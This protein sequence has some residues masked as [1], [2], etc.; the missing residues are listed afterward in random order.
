[1]L[2]ELFGSAL[3]YLI[4]G[5]ALLLVGIAAIT[6]FVLQAVLDEARLEQRIGAAV[7]DWTG[8]PLVATGGVD[9]EL[10]PQPVLTLHRPRLGAIEDGFVLSADRLDLDVAF[11]SLF[12]GSLAVDVASLIRPELRLGDNPRAAFDGL[13]ERLGADGERLPFRRLD[14]V[15]GTLATLADE[16]VLREIDG[17]LEREGETGGSRFHAVGRLAAGDGGSHLRLEG[18]L[19]SAAADRPLPLQLQLEAT[20][21]AVAH[22]LDF[23]GQLSRDAS[24]S[25][26][27]GRMTLDLPSSIAPLAAELAAAWP[28]LARLPL[29]EAPLTLSGDLSMTVGEAP[30]TLR[31]EQAALV[32]DGQAL[33][34]SLLLEGGVAP[35]IDL[36]LDADRLVLEDEVLDPARLASRLGEILPPD[37][38]G[39]IAL[40]AAV[41]EWRGEA[42]RQV[43][44]DLLLDGLGM[45][46]V[47]RATAVLPG[48]GDLA[49]TGQYGP[50]AGEPPPRL[51]GRLEAA[52]QAP[53][54]LAAAL[55]EPPAVLRHS[56][57]LAIEAD[58]EWQPT[59]L[60]LQNA[61]LRL[62]ALRAVG[63]LAYRG[64][65]AGRLPQVAVWAS[66][67]RLAL[68]DVVNPAS[69]AA[70]LDRLFEL[71]R[72][73]DLAIDLRVSRTSLAEARFGSLTARLD[74]SDGAVAIERL[75]LNDV[76]GSAVTLSGRVHAPSRTFELDLALDLASVSRLLRLGGA[77][78]PVALALLGPLNLRGELAGDL[79]R[80]ELT[81]V[82]DAD[83]F[84][85]R[86]VASITDWREHPSAAL[87]FSLDAGDA[88]PLIRQLGGVA[89][90]ETLA[91]GPLTAQVELDIVQGGLRATVL[92][93]SLG[94]LELV[95]EASRAD[96]GK[97]PPDRFDLRLGPLSGEMA[98]LLYRLATPPLDLVPGPPARWLGYWPAQELTWDWL[99]A[100][101]AE[102]AVTLLG[103]DPDTPPIE[104]R[105]QLRDGALTVPAFRWAGPDGL[106]DAGLALV[107][108]G[109]GGGV[110]LTLDLALER[111]SAGGVLA[112]VWPGPAAVHGTLD[113]EARLATRGGSLRA[114]VSNLQ[115]ALDLVLTDGVLGAASPADG[116][117]PVERLAGTL[118]VERGVI[119]PSASGFAFS[120]PDGA[121]L[122]EGYADLL[123]WIVDLELALDGHDGTPL[124]RQRLFG[125]LAE[126]VAL[127]SLRGALEGALPAP[128]E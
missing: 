67:D 29:P 91:Q 70:E 90:G 86:G 121:G 50:L 72:S 59:R 96:A 125:P 68:D 31:L 57:T 54:E 22:R 18:Q 107:A 30:P 108:R 89:V 95:L 35:E 79:D 14:F 37:L 27:A 118:A 103:G 17:E 13:A 19:G 104:I 10:L 69:P 32:L 115:G 101:E 11:W 40:R 48:P 80:A 24:A 61:D 122:I 60:T 127:P 25:G 1:M 75:S 100:H 84:T 116:G 82:L 38:S 66:I 65:A 64:D 58:L 8:H 15:G 42:F 123:A 2:P 81:A 88:A 106:I 45:V 16:V 105:S 53:A 36:R 98:A 28:G 41:V 126:P 124:V 92:E 3:R 111:F 102:L 63:G 43:N 76:A 56:T 119:S 74:S 112:P 23:R 109:P 114:L 34:G 128:E 71:A 9:L 78:P 7:L 62:D 4:G 110:D 12:S 39:P 52:L 113:L 33:T 93:L 83:L 49:F 44:V 21:A 47:V 73:T 20:T 55:I 120:G 99:H 6:F 85:G 26:L 97:G 46:D 87:A 77:E 5:A 94:Q 51:T 117:I